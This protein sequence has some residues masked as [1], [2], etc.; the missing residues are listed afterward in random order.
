M[1][2]GKINDFESKNAEQA[3][4]KVREI[5]E[6]LRAA[7]VKGIEIDF[8]DH[9]TGT[10]IVLGNQFICCLQCEDP[11]FMKNYLAVLANAVNPKSFLEQV[12]V[13]HFQE[14]IPASNFRKF[15]TK[16]VNSTQATKE[17]KN[18]TQ[19]ERLHHIYHSMVDIGNQYWAA[20]DAGKADSNLVQLLKNAAVETLPCGDE[21]N[22]ALGKDETM[23]IAEWVE[24]MGPP[25]ILLE[26]ELCWPVEPELTY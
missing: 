14:E 8:L 12:W 19:F 4:R 1:L 13:L 22:S 18:W 26:K 23:N 25:D 21:L 5:F 16:S 2:A 9:M 10:C 24:F 3:E 17:I 11:I 15:I 7:N 20:V 6:G